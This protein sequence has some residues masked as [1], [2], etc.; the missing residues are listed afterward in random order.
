VLLG[1]GRYGHQPRHQ[2]PPV[3]GR[4]EHEKRREQ[5]PVLL[6]SRPGLL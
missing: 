4:L 1:C 6:R 3:P 2:C 5:H